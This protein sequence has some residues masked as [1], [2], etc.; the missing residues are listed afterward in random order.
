[1]VCLGQID[2]NKCDVYIE[3]VMAGSL[4]MKVYGGGGKAHS[5]MKGLGSHMRAVSNV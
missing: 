1:M 2:K 5:T 3:I 4:Q